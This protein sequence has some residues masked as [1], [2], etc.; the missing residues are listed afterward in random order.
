VRSVEPECWKYWV[1]QA[2]AISEC[3]GAQALL[4]YAEIINKGNIYFP[5]YEEFFSQ[6]EVSLE[7][8]DPSQEPKPSPVAP[9]PTPEPIQ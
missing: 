3:R 7:N 2:Q 5:D 6:F 1:K 8:R 9:T 4:K